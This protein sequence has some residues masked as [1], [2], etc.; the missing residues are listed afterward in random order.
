MKSLTLKEI[1][2]A[3]GG[4]INDEKFYDTRIS[5]VAIDSRGNR[6]DL[7]NKLFIPFVGKNVDAHS[8]IGDVLQKGAE[9]VLSEK[10]QELDKP[11]IYVENTKESIMKLAGYYRS[12]FGLRVIGVTGS[13]GKTTTKDLIAS[14]MSQKY[15][16]IKTQGN[17]NNE[18]GLPLT[19]FN[20]DDTTE[21]AVLEMG[22][23]D[24]GEIHALAQ[25]SLPQTAVITNIGYSH[26]ERLKSREGI[27]KAKCEIF[28]FMHFSDSLGSLD[29]LDSNTNLGILNGDDDMLVRLKE[30]NFVKNLIFYGTNNDNDFYASDVKYNGM[31]G[32]SFTINVKNGGKIN[33]D[34]PMP[35]KHMVLNALCAAAV[36]TVHGLSLSQIKAGIESFK[37]SGLRMEIFRNEKGVTVLN[38]VYNASP[39]SMKAAIDVLND[40]YF[41]DEQCGRKFCLLGD[42][43]EL[44]DFSDRLHYETG[45]Y[46]AS[47]GID[48][49]L[50]CGD[51]SRSIYEG[52]KTNSKLTSLHF[53][54]KNEMIDYTLN[55]S[56][57]GDMILVK[58]SRGMKFEEISDK[59]RDWKQGAED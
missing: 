31:Q 46:A 54:S 51:K 16:T 55:H 10:K 45:E 52:A 19:I 6:A 49:I 4:R 32:V 7:E 27:L 47:L 25:I 24:F 35:G 30:G 33:V 18:I 20:I 50:T 3:V 26:I 8:F 48:Y 23:S 2:K 21:A 29:F 36:G 40:M 58:A 12:I 59:L 17:F 34:V 41:Q 37:P 38:D 11:V 44:G 22:M 39:S 13:V 42:M 9:A 28:D 56:E 43:L 5:G 57:A 14:V 53:D 15:R 1:E